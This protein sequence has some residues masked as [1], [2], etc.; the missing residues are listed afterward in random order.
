MSET[1]GI[2]QPQ[3]VNFAQLMSGRYFIIPA[4]QRHYAWTEKEC[5]ELFDD[6]VLTARNPGRERFMST[7]T[8]ISPAGDSIT[9]TY[10]D[11]KFSQLKPLWVVDGQQRL[12]SM[13]ILISCICRHILQQGGDEAAIR[14]A[15]ADFVKTPLLD[16][17]PILRVRP[18]AIP[19]HPE[20][21]DDFFTQVVAIDGDIKDAPLEMLIPAQ[22][23]LLQAR[24]LFEAGLRDLSEA[25]AEA[26]VGLTQLLTCVASRL[27]FI[28]NTLGNVGQAGEVFEGLNN[29]G[30]ALSVLENLKAFSVY[31]VQSF[32]NHEALP[33]GVSGTASDLNDDF[34]DAIGSVYHH[35]DRVGLRDDVAGDLLAASWPLVSSRIAAAALTKAGDAPTEMLDRAKV[36]TGV[37]ESLHLQKASSEEQKASLLNALSFFVCTR[38]V[39]ASRHFADARRP[40]EPISFSGSKLSPSDLQ[41][42]RALHQRLSVMETTAPFLP[43][44]LA[45]RT[46]APEAWSEYL[47]L[48]RLVERAAF[49]TYVFGEKKKGTGQRLLARLARDL[50]DGVIDFDGLL[51]ALHAFGVSCGR[52][53][54]IHSFSEDEISFEEEM[55]S[56]LDEAKGDALGIIAFEWLLYH[57]SKLPS[58]GKFLKSVRDERVLKLVSNK[59]GKKP[60]GIEVGANEI[61]GPGN[62]IVLDGMPPVTPAS[63]F[64]AQFDSLSYSEKRRMLS[65]L[66]YGA[67]LPRDAI[68][69][70]WA[71]KQRRDMAKFVVERWHLPEDGRIT[72]ATWSTRPDSSFGI[73]VDA[74]EILLN[75]DA[76]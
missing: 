51:V 46:I 24:K 54:N 73:L 37:R 53:T 72:E 69:S 22:K 6:C 57:G 59:R 23:R 75:E 68:T 63:E 52:T 25:P 67:S 64:R 43:I 45:Q 14:N 38:L 17:S 55:E 27:I 2:A 61:A 76:E 47:L 41:E 13:L 4:Y 42:V 10:T 31:A 32:R 33:L 1:I 39:P 8:A 40:L 28:L 58:L 62:V 56:H 44:L 70:N 7:I 60:S 74:D 50:I 18:Q 29:R 5:Q 30:L 11:Q 21:M 12:T 26:R 35:L 3:R 15:Y 19:S 71:N 48:S 16:H 20:L 66:G 36:M 34:N 65:Q 49:R 9:P